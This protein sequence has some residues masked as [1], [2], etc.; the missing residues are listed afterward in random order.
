MKHPLRSALLALLLSDLSGCCALKAGPP[1]NAAQLLES[2]HTQQP[3]SFTSRW[4]NQQ[5]Q[6]ADVEDMD[7]FGG[8]PVLAWVVVVDVI[9]CIV[10]FAGMRT[11]SGLA[12]KKAEDTDYFLQSPV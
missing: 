11:V 8:M 7:Y 12:R 6:L 2:H 5:K 9:A 3:S 10:Y 1:K 4:S